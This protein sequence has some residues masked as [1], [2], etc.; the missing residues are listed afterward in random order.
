MSNTIC[1]IVAAALLLVGPV[2]ALA[3]DAGDVK[4]FRPGRDGYM[5]KEARYQPP[6]VAIAF[7]LIAPAAI[8]A[9]AFKSARRTHL[10]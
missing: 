9:P 7:G 10:N 2:A 6:W 5:P 8:L 1:L 4:E 3:G